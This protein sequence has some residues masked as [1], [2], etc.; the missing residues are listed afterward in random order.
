[1]RERISKLEQLF[2]ALKKKA[3]QDRVEHKETIEKL[4]TRLD[5]QGIQRDPNPEQL[6]ESSKKA[7]ADADTIAK[8]KAEI[9]KL[10][11]QL[12]KSNASVRK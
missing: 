5:E 3:L 11:L 2:Q 9:F 1:M 6:Q 12:V 10:K 8:L 4:N 7:N